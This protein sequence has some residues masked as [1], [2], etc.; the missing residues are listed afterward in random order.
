MSNAILTGCLKKTLK[1][2]SATILRFHDQSVASE[3]LVWDLIQNVFG[4]LYLFQSFIFNIYTMNICFVHAKE[5][6]K[7]LQIH[8]SSCS[9]LHIPPNFPGVSPS[10]HWVTSAWLIQ[11]ST[12]LEADT[13]L[14]WTSFPDSCCCFCFAIGQGFIV[15]HSTD[16]AFDV[17]WPSIQTWQSAGP[18]SAV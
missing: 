13:S 18:S 9:I 4:F 8:H 2:V 3:T 10:R 12:C 15:F 6:T 5:Y 11:P 7:Q 16:L 1:W 17:A 14:L